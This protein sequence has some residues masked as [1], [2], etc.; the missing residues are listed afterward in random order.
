MAPKQVH[1]VDGFDIMLKGFFYIAMS[2]FIKYRGGFNKLVWNYRYGIELCNVAR[3]CTDPCVVVLSNNDTWGHRVF[4]QTT[5]DN[6]RVQWIF[7]SC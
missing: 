5:R 6:F 3:N 2:T 4:T 1:T 7:N